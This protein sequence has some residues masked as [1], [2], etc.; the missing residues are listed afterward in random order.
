ME[1]ETR[2]QSSPIID[3]LLREPRKYSFVQAVR[4]MALHFA[5]AYGTDD[6]E[7][8][9]GFLKSGIRIIPELTLGHPSTDI[10]KLIPLPQVDD[11]ESQE[12]PTDKVKKHPLYE[13][14]ATFL[15]LY[16]TSSPL[17]TFYTEELIE[18]ARLDFSASRD[19]LNIFNQAL[20]ELYY[21]AFNHYKLPFRSIEQHDKQSLHMQYCFL[22]FGSETLR[23]DAHVEHSHL[24][25]IGFFAKQQRST[26]ALQRALILHTGIQHIHIEECIPRKM[27]IPHEQR[28]T[29]GGT[30]AFLGHAVIGLHIHD[31]E[32]K[33]HIHL[34]DVDLADLADYSPRGKKHESLVYFLRQ[35]IFDPL[36]YDL[37]LHPRADIRH[38]GVR[39]G[40][41]A[42]YGLGNEAFLNN[43]H[44]QV[45]KTTHYISR[46]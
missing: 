20:Y 32:G 33:F 18:E 23:R 10:A 44:S 22:G 26:H 7:G 29:L 27:P 43:P 30:G 45:K 12:A 14:T 42:Q 41:T 35:F 25:Y 38:A 40:K 15:A 46:Y 21:R 19:F 39:L 4:L 16:G 13:L 37:V 24:R 9:R 3:A 28:C 1:S 5:H 34:H 6:Y 8:T 17:P 31:I 36:E 2:Q 11:D